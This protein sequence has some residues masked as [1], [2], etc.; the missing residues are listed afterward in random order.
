MILIA[1]AG[2]CLLSVPAAG[3]SLRRLA[4]IRI[5]AGW[6]PMVAVALQVLITVIVS[7][8]SPGAHRAVH[9]ATYVM[10][11]A[12]LWCNRHLPGAKVIAAG[13][14]LNAVAIVANDG[15]MPASTWAQHIAGMH[16]AAGGFANSSHVTHALL[17]WLGDVIPWPGP[18]PNVLSAG[19]LVVYAG[20]L[21]L[22]HRA[23]R[24]SAAVPPPPLDPVCD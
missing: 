4:D 18:L 7:S 12:F 10:I 16:P 21:V 24:P 1:L 22:L 6:L 23:C 19:D 8:G 14:L 3:G 11:V 15:V 2:L 13:A 5:R 17:P 9:M 20:M